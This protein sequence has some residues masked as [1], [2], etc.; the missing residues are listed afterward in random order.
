MSENHLKLDFGK[1]CH[2]LVT[3]P[4]L[5]IDEINRK[6][7]LIIER[8]N[9]MVKQ[10]IT[11]SNF[12][13]VMTPT[14]LNTLVNMYDELFFDNNIQKSLQEHGCVLTVCFNK[15]CLKVAGKCYYKKDVNY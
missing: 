15:R 1:I 13:R 6:R 4:K 9:G 10:E 5:P 11:L 8:L 2:K 7:N 14:V 3:G 12:E